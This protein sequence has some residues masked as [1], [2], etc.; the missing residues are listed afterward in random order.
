MI[1]IEGDEPDE[2]VGVKY[3]DIRSTDDLFMK[4]KTLILTLQ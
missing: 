2:A 4:M 1:Y 3:S